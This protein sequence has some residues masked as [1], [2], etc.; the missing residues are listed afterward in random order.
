MTTLL[1]EF[2]RYR[3]RFQLPCMFSKMTI[4]NCQ[5][6]L[7]MNHTKGLIMTVN[8][9][10]RTASNKIQ[11]GP[12]GNIPIWSLLMSFTRRFK[13]QKPLSRTCYELQQ[14]VSASFYWLP[15][16]NVW[17]I[18]VR[19]PHLLRTRIWL[20]MRNAKNNFLQRGTK[21]VIAVG[22]LFDRRTACIYIGRSWLAF[23]RH[24]PSLDL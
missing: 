10:V 22:W 6:N 13:R 12:S 11:D 5:P 15:T 21:N 3:Q 23:Q 16:S 18:E 24:V 14:S 19:C 17:I 7:F 20:N 2:H 9:K 1:K 4:G 8:S